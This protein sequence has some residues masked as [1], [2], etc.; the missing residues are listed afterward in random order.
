MDNRRRLEYVMFCGLH[1][2][3]RKRVNG[4]SSGRLQSFRYLR[5]PV[6]DCSPEQGEIEQ[7]DRTRGGERSMVE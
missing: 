4:V 5:R 2:G 3:S 6:H 7:D 1:G